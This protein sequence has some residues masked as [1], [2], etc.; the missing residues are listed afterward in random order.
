MRFVCWFRDVRPHAYARLQAI[1]PLSAIIVRLGNCPGGFPDSWAGRRSRFSGKP[2]GSITAS[3]WS[4]R[5]GLLA[6]SG[7]AIIVGAFVTCWPFGTMAV[8]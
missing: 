3:L 8:R 2:A 1:G 6:G 5:A 4:A 7:L